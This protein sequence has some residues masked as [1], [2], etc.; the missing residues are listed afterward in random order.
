MSGDVLSD[1]VVTLAPLAVADAAEW[2]AGEDSEALRWFEAPGPASIAST[3]RFIRS[4]QDSWAVMGGHRHW[5]IRSAESN[6]LLGGV[7]LRT[8]GIEEVNLSYVVFPP[9]R[10][11]GFALRACR[12]VLRYGAESMGAQTAVI[13]MLPGNVASR[14]LALRLGAEFVGHAPSDGGST[15]HVFKLSLWSRW[16]PTEFP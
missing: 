5:G 12:L 4:C 14:N 2:L 15:F 1:G 8:L 13:K 7:D 9:F 10:Q 3:E 11:L 16:A 6:A